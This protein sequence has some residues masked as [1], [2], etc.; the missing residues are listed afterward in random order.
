MRQIETSI[1]RNQ[2]SAIQSFPQPK[3]VLEVQR[4]LGLTGYFR[5]FIKNYSIRARPLYDL[6]SIAMYVLIHFRLGVSPRF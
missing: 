2:M 3:S 6:S 1:F 4:F 5:K